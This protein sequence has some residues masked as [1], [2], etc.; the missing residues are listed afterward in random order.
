MICVGRVLIGTE[1]FLFEKTGFNSIIKRHDVLQL[2][3]LKSIN[4]FKNTC[5]KMYV[6]TLLYILT[7]NDQIFIKG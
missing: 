7:I 1:H 6:H 5:F 4:L 2:N 3:L